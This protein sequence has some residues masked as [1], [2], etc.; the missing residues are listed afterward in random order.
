MGSNRIQ[1]FDVS[2][3]QREVIEWRAARRKQLREEYL[4]QILHPKKQEIVIDS[5][6]QRF[7]IMRLTHEYQ[8]KLTG[9]SFVIG[10]CG[11]LGFIA[12]CMWTV[13]GVK[14]RQEHEYRSGL[15]SYADR[16]FKFN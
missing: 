15:V 12:L 3:K 10:F 2:P 4:R 5:A 9:K 16:E 14:N 7:G 8:V 1:S 13:A 11:T 6:M